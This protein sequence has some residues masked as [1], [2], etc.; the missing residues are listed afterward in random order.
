MS[1][2]SPVAGGG[3]ASWRALLAVD[4]LTATDAVPVACQHETPSN[5][6]VPARRG[7]VLVIDDE[8]VGRTIQRL[9]SGQHDVLVEHDARAAVA[10][11]VAGERFDAVLCELTMPHLSGIQVYLAIVRA[12]PAA[13]K[14]LVFTSGGALSDDAELFLQTS[15]SVMLEKPF[16]ISCLRSVVNG[17]VH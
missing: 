9:L 3:Y 16:C 12:N 4:G 1:Q 8:L 13:A 6:L 14:R 10:R 7:T 5:M 2:S 17:L 15:Q 11:L